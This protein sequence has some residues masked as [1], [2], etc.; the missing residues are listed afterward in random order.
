MG[1]W[2]LFVGNRSTNGVLEEWLNQAV[3]TIMPKLQLRVGS[4]I[5]R[6]VMLFLKFGFGQS[7]SFFS[8]L[9]ACTFTWRPWSGEDLM[10]PCL[11]WGA[12][13]TCVVLFPH[14]R[15]VHA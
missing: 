7:C 6:S 14:E 11:L 1:K 15:A 13:G 10:V 3:M 9:F 5:R 2:L 8:W 12:G 4:K